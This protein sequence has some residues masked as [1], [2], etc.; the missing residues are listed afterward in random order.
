MLDHQS[1]INIPTTVARGPVWVST[2]ILYLLAYDATDVMDNNNLA[3]ALLAQI[4]IS[5]TLITVRKLSV[6]SVVFAM[7]WGITP[8]KAQ[9]TKQATTQ[10]RMR[11]MLHPLLSRWLRTND[12]AHP[13]FSD[14]MFVST[15]SRNGTRCA[16]VYATDFGWD[17]ASQLHPEVKHMRPCCCYNTKDM[18]DG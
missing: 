17:R 15:V 13:V 6:E 14:M 3:T 10:R 9:K 2:A 11:I 5:F 4:H 12:L 16:Q 1:Q 7:R 8:E 18:I